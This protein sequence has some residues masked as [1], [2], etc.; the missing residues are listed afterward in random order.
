MRL[1]LALL[2]MILGISVPV[3]AVG[4]VQPTYAEGQV[5][6]YKAR[7]QDA[8]SRLKIQRIEIKSDGSRVFHISVS[9]VHFRANNIAPALPHLPVSEATL[10][11]SVTSLADDPASFPPLD[12][13]AGVAE[14]RSAKGGVF[15]IPMEAVI[16]YVDEIVS[17]RSTR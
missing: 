8:G 11:A 14:W 5:W 3:A 7:P 4:S 2:F 13:E 10:D 16:Q 1:W 15:T 9:G 12:F 17:S 6:L